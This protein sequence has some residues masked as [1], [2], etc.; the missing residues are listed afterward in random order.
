MLMS[1]FAYTLA[2]YP[3]FFKKD[4]K[5]D[6]KVIVPNSESHQFIFVKINLQD[7]LNLSPSETHI[8][9]DTTSLEQNLVLV[10]NSCDNLLVDKLRGFPENCRQ[11]LE[12]GQ[13]RIELIQTQGGHFIIIVEGY[14]MM[15]LP[16]LSNLLREHKVNGT[17]FVY[18]SQSIPT[19]YIAYLHLR[20]DRLNRLTVEGV[21]HTFKFV[22]VKDYKAIIEVDDQIQPERNDIC[23]YE[24]LSG[25][26]PEHIDFVE[27]RFKS[28]TKPKPLE[29]TEPVKEQPAENQSSI[30]N[31]TQAQDTTKETQ[32]EKKSFFWKIIEWFL[33]LFR[34]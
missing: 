20:K 5:I 26:V 8:P 21:N 28:C 12:R 11:N 29:T 34:R 33:N 25:A 7:E 4:G 17:N 1:V 10:G 30:E 9:N 31:T 19:D 15:I 24:D 27:I 16:E 14:D 13:G 6:V 23:P 18:N 32:Q 22:N 3:S 2:D